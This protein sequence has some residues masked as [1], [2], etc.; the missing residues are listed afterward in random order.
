MASQHY[1]KEYSPIDKLWSSSWLPQV[2]ED[3]HQVKVSASVKQQHGHVG[4]VPHDGQVQ[5]RVAADGCIV[6]NVDLGSG[7]EK[8]PHAVQVA[9]RAGDV[10]G[11]LTIL[12]DSN[13]IK[14]HTF[15]TP[16]LALIQW[17]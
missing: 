16:Y 3:A 11:C 2:Q 14:I 9:P 10:Q 7:V 13:L 15:F 4:V 12:K 5:G 1:K 17:S 8:V 6:G